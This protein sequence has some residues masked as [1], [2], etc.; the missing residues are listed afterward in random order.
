MC[1]SA[2]SQLVS[3][4]P[5]FLGLRPDR[6][7]K[8]WCGTRGVGK[9]NVHWFRLDQFDDPPEELEELKENA[10]GRVQISTKNQSESILT[11][12]NLQEDD[13]GVYFCRVNGSWG[14]GTELRVASKTLA[15]G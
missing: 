4:L 9:F 10:G 12:V 11:I 6:I 1:T 2:G 7:S 15:E 13:S 14:P 3:Q 8:I 5:R